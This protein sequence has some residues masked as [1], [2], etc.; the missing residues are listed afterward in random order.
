M[1]SQEAKSANNDS[2]ELRAQIQDMEKQLLEMKK[3]LLTNTK[4]E[5]NSKS[6]DS[7]DRESSEY[8]YVYVLQADL[9]SLCCDYWFGASGGVLE[10]S[11]TQDFPDSADKIQVR[12]VPGDDQMEHVWKMWTYEPWPQG[13]PRPYT[14]GVERSGKTNTAEY[15]AQV[16]RYLRAAAQHAYP[17]SGEPFY[18]TF[19]KSACPLMATPLIGTGWGGNKMNTGEMA[20]QLLPTLYSLANELRIDVALVTNDKEV[21]AMMQWARSKMLSSSHAGG[22]DEKESSLQ[23]TISGDRFLHSDHQQ[24][25]HDLA[26]H[27]IQG[28]LSL[29]IGAGASMGSNVPDWGGLVDSLAEELGLTEERKAE[30][31]EVDV[32]TKAAVLEAEVERRLQGGGSNTATATA[33]GA[34]GAGAGAAA[35]GGKEGRSEKALCLGDYVA[36]RLIHARYSVVHALLASLPVQEV[37]LD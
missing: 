35:E 13:V 17:P 19:R 37:R 14:L 30:F 11:L 16:G 34:A 10:P 8:G 23:A 36:R 20:L 29:F 1:S 7:N 9:T 22:E 2:E 6:R 21:Y 26:H 32:Y 27:A 24:R 25:I 31:A 12:D 18:S 15:V 28:Q 3:A 4:E 33:A 5:K